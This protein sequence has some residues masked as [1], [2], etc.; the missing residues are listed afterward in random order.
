MTAAP[1]VKSGDTGQAVKNWQALLVAREYSLGTT[2]PKR[3][4]V[5]GTFGAATDKATRAFQQA[6]KLAV[7][8]IAGALTLRA[9]LAG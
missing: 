2:G 6:H 9:A 1:T 8:G 3:D 7:D 5:D 4:G